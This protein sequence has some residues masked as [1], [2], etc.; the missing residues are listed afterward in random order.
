MKVAFLFSGQLRNVPVGLFRKSLYNL[1]N[2]LN[3]DIYAYLWDET[4]K[5]LNHSTKEVKNFNTENPKILMNKLFT[6][7]KLKKVK[8]DSF[9]TFLDNLDPQYKEI[10]NSKKYHFGTINS[11]PQ[12]YTLSKCFKLISQELY[13]YDLIFRCRFD[14][15]FIHPITLYN[16]EKIK[17]NNN[18][19]N[20]NFGRAYYPKRIYDIFFGGSIE[21]MLFLNDIWEKYIE[22]IND[23][24]NNN[25]DKRDACRIIYLAANKNNIKVS[26][27]DTRICDIFR[28]FK[29][30]YYERYIISMHLF[31]TKNLI[32]NIKFL[33]YFFQWFKLRKFKKANIIICFLKTSIILPISYLKRFKYIHIFLKDFIFKFR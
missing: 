24:F 26:S 14:S 33:P 19:Y 4:G 8:Y 16:L 29:K 17:Q 21:S 10:Y 25:L 5:S 23:N 28:N 27:F 12:I 13:N 2:N 15:F 18:L 20:L 1:T 11:M 7:F 6:G 22:L 3:Y 32:K 9:K 30:N 31:K